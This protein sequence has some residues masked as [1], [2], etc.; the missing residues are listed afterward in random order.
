[1]EQRADILFIA[2]GSKNFGM[3]HLSRC[4]KI[5]QF[6]KNKTKDKVKIIFLG[7]VD[8][9]G[10]K[11]VKENKISLIE[12][13]SLD[14][15][16]ELERD[17]K[18]IRPKVIINDNQ[19]LNSIEYYKFLKKNC[20]LLIVIDDSLNAQYVTDILVNVDPSRYI[21][22]PKRKNLIFLQGP[23]YLLL[24]YEVDAFHYE[25]T[26]DILIFF[27]GTDYRDR[28]LELAVL[29]AN[30]MKDKKITVIAKPKEGVPSNIRIVEPF[31]YPVTSL[32]KFHNIIITSGG[33]AML[34]SIY[35]KKPTFVFAA[36][37]WE[38]ENIRYFEERSLVKFLGTYE[39]YSK[40]LLENFLNYLKSPLNFA[41]NKNLIDG[42]GIARI[43]AIIL[44]MINE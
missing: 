15:L 25:I 39:Y 27:G 12:L 10:N 28:A 33:T 23:K 8:S 34:E 42:K 22:R 44:K 40:F 37:P 38:R 14:N 32:L 43:G 30:E 1:M 9:Y 24:P 11:F 19:V 18:K 17:V 36:Q 13:S 7:H 16:K 4:S 35:F 41:F 5:F 3:G 31:T 21:K 20:K 26:G 29:V 2:H 6:L